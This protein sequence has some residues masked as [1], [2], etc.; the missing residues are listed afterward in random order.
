M[1]LRSSGS[2][3]DR[4]QQE[5]DIAA[6]DPGCTTVEDD[7]YCVR[8][9]DGNIYKARPAPTRAAR[10]PASVVR[11]FAASS[12]RCEAARQPARP[13]IRPAIN[14]SNRRRPID[15]RFSVPSSSTS[16]RSTPEPA[17]TTTPSAQSRPWEKWRGGGRIGG[18]GGG[19]TA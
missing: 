19:Y 5:R 7:E 9:V 17:R 3:R 14:W 8:C 1:G 10:I 15:R 6:C 11:T 2:S 18:G 16:R 13:G 12:A 4:E